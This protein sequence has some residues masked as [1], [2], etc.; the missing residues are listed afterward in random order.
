[1]RIVYF[2]P[3]KDPAIRDVENALE[4]CQKLVG[5]YIET[6]YPFSSNDVILVCNE[7]GRFMELKPNRHIG[8]GQFSETILGPFFLVGSDDEGNL[9]S[10]SEEC[11]DW[12]V[13]NE[14]IYSRQL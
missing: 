4:E 14:Q 13:R 5:G 8:T 2:E 12:L 1:M 9:C 11:A 7:D 10:L 6:V 3:G